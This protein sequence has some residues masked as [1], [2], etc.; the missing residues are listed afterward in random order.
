MIRNR[1]WKLF[2]PIL[3][4]GIIF[5]LPAHGQSASAAASSSAQAKT[6]KTGYD[7]AKEVKI[8]GVIE[9]IDAT[10]ANTPMGTHILVMT[11]QGEVDAHL[12]FGA[13][14][15][16]TRLGIE[17]GQTV[18]VLGMMESIGGNQVL[19]TR[20]LTTPSQ[21]FVLRNEHGIPVRGA[22]NNNANA[23]HTQKGGL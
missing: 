7:L 12:G 14:A 17:E 15:K 3:A 5:I 13:A 18:T 16:P 11:P 6:V 21:I 1:N 19:L 4:A 2:L 10:S 9:K 23:A 22:T 20:L 8:E